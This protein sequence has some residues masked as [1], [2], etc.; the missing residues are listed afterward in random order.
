MELRPLFFKYITM[1]SSNSSAQTKYEARDLEQE[2]RDARE[3]DGRSIPPSFPPERILPDDFQEDVDAD[4]PSVP[5]SSIVVL[6]S[7][8]VRSQCTT[9]LGLYGV[10]LTNQSRANDVEDALNDFIDSAREENKGEKDIDNGSE[11]DDWDET[12]EEYDTL[13]DSKWN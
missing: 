12:D 8:T 10:D 4:I 3:F 13:T 1:K 7:R 2:G 9:A 11:D 6:H 5:E